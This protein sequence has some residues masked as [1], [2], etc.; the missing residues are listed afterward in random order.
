MV[1]VRRLVAHYKS[2]PIPE[3]IVTEEQDTR[4]SESTYSYLK[5][6]SRLSEF[7]FLQTNNSKN[8]N[9]DLPE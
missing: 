4:G 7:S 5:A 6:N 9:V 1:V 2:G 8:N 3:N